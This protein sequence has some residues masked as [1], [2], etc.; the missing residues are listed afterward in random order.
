[1]TN[2]EWL[3][4]A[5]QRS[6]QE[7]WTLGYVFEQYLK[8]EHK[9]VEQLARE[10]DCPLEVLDWLA[11]CRRPDEDRFAEHL[12]LIEKRFAVDPRRLAAVLRH[13]EVMEGL[14]EGGEDGASRDGSFLRA[15]R[16]H[17]DDE[18]DR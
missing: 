8:Q 6:G 18:T 13:V 15:A 2:P 16:D 7:S 1:M 4:V 14:P 3:K 17:S 5:A 9:S 11:L 12:G 10:L